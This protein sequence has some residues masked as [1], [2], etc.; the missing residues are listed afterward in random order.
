M[1]KSV[2]GKRGLSPVIA[3]VLM[4]LLVLVL[5]VIIFLWARGFVSE[6][7]EKFGK[8]IEE[9]CDSVD[10]MAERYGDD[11]EIVNRGNV[12]IHHLDI[13]MSSGGNS[14]INKFDFKIDAGKAVRESVTLRLFDGS[15]PEEM[16]VYPALIGNVRDKNSNKIFTCMDAGR[17]L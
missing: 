1:R 9:M 11:L 13:K 3:S 14:E 10:F 4:I 16:T 7:I 6:Q 5:S 15:A 2:E 8:P 12:D 17:T